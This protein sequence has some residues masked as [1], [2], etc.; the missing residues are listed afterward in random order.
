MRSN[1]VIQN[2]L[3]AQV[4]LLHQETKDTGILKSLLLK[5]AMLIFKTF[6]LLNKIQLQNRSDLHGRAPA[7]TRVA[8]H[9][10][11]TSLSETVVQEIFDRL[12]VLYDV[13]RHGVGNV[14]YQVPMLDVRSV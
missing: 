2:L 1:K 7:D 12:Q 3:V 5:T 10:S 8:M 6:I 9:Q 13:L 4:V 11:T 14:H